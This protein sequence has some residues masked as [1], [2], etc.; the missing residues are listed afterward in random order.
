VARSDE[1]IRREARIQQEEADKREL[2]GCGLLILFLVIGVALITVRGLWIVRDEPD[3]RPGGYAPLSSLSLIH[4]TAMLT[5]E[6]S[7]NAESAYM[8]LGLDGDESAPPERPWTSS[9]GLEAAMM[10]HDAHYRECKRLNLSIKPGAS[11]GLD[12]ATVTN[13]PA[14]SPATES[15]CFRRIRGLSSTSAW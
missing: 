6:V 8:A 3:Y 2:K 1:E 9:N 4:P 12:P 10:T 7:R 13:V 5:K 15:R 11:R 14:A